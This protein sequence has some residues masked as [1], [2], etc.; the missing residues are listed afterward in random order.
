MMTPLDTP[1]NLLLIQHPNEVM[2]ST[3]T[4]KVLQWRFSSC[5]TEVWDR[6]DPP[7][8]LLSTIEQHPNPVLLFPTQDSQTLSATVWQEAE[9]L[10]IVLDATWQEAKKMWRQSPWLQ[11]LATYHLSIEQESHFTL[12]RN[13]KPNSVCTC[14]IGIELLSAHGYAS[15][16]Q[17]LNESMQHYFSAFQADRS[18]HA[19][20]R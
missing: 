5:Q 11:S 19:F 20:K 8:A 17:S 3:N 14:E 16:A 12:R 10:Y 9:P 18:G 7:N 6:S 15:K 13:Q 4:A 2:R 1:F